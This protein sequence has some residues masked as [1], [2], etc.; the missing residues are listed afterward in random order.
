MNVIYHNR[1][2]STADLDEGAK[3]VEFD[4]LLARSDV[5]SPL[6]GVLDQDALV[7]AI[8][9]GS[10]WSAGLGVYQKKLDIHPG[11]VSK[12]HV[13]L[14]PHMGISTVEIS[15]SR[16]SIETKYDMENLTISNVRQALENGTLRNVV[17]EQS[18]Q[19]ECL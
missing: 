6:N 8:A 4:E 17:I 16:W 12:S 18:E 5:L 9:D 14:L 13:C 1:A 2:K 19:A 15:S 3:Y 10:V 7:E 11:L